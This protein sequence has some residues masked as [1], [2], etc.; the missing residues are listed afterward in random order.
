M[1]PKFFYPNPAGIRG[2]LTNAARGSA[3]PAAP[4]TSPAFCRRCLDVFMPAQ[5]DKIFV[6]LFAS[7]V[8]DIGLDD[9]QK[10]QADP[11][12]SVSLGRRRQDHRRS[13]K[14]I[15]FY[16]R[17]AHSRLGAQRSFARRSLSFFRHERQQIR[18]LDRKMV[19]PSHFKLK[20][21]YVELSRKW[22]DGDVDRP[23]SADAGTPRFG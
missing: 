7:S 18:H 22:K 8:A 15:A 3:A 11:G 23:Q 1:A 20:N 13:G 16:D 17:R 19:R 6:N 2:Q 4:A 12:H 9:G 21:G 5:S 10:I 14:K